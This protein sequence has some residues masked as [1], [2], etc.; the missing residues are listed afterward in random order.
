MTPA[1]DAVRALAARID[2]VLPQ[3]QCTRCGYPD[4]AAY[5]LA[6][7]TAEAG[8]N[9]CPPGGAEGVERLAALTQRPVRPLSPE[10]GTEGPRAVAF[11]DEAW[12]IGCTLCLK[13][14]PTDAILGANKQMHTVIED[15]CTGC[16]LCI[17]VCP[18]DC[19][20][21][22]NASGSATGWTAW[23]ASQAGHARD[24]Y[25]A[26]TRRLDRDAQAA[27]ALLPTPEPATASADAG[28]ASSSAPPGDAKRAAIAA[29]MARAR[30]RR[31]AG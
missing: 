15:H 30:A 21:L 16:E 13:A 24:R 22:E 10:H 31:S 25:A 6:V 14:C 27:P 11:I 26:R 2:A 8:I 18:V 1:A 12:C 20:V 19:I 9:Q 5:A 7:A 23:S 29:A 4:C 17:P 28:A 3:T